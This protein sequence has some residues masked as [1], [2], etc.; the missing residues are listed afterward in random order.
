MN[1]MSVNVIG[2]CLKNLLT[3]FLWYFSSCCKKSNFI[4]IILYSDEAYQILDYF[5]K[6]YK[7]ICL[8]MHKMNDK[9]TKTTT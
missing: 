5:C 9:L 8:I 2:K 4:N 1:N 3:V 7:I 6:T